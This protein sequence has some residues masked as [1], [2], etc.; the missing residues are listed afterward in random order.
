MASCRFFRNFIDLTTHSGKNRCR[1]IMKMTPQE[2]IL[3][4]LQL[5]DEMRQLCSPMEGITI[6]ENDLK[7]REIPTEDFSRIM[8]KL[9]S[10]GLIFPHTEEEIQLDGGLTYR[11]NVI[12]GDKDRFKNYANKIH[13]D[14]HSDISALQG[15]KFLA[16]ADVL[17]DIYGQLQITQGPEVSIRIVPQIVR[18]SSLMPADSVGMR[19]RYGDLR[20]EAVRYLHDRNLIVK[21]EIVH[22][23]HRWESEVSLSIDR[24]PFQSFYDRF[25]E[26]YE[27]RVVKDGQN[28]TPTQSQ[29]ALS[30]EDQRLLE[31]AKNR[32]AQI[33]ALTQILEKAEKEEV[34]QSTK[35]NKEPEEQTQAIKLPK[36]TSWEDVI[37]KFID[38]ENVKIFGKGFEQEASYKEMGFQNNKKV[39]RTPNKQ[40]LFLRSL[41]DLEGV[42]T[43]DSPRANQTLKKTKQLL[44]Y[45]LKAYFK[46]SG[47]P[48]GD[49]KTEKG[50]RIRMQLIPSHG[51]VVIPPE[52]KTDDEFGIEEELG[53]YNR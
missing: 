40:W 24:I 2:K 31:N 42:I 1:I 30:E 11:Y 25:A 38:G 19:D 35:T 41:A 39:P 13:T 7:E 46:L 51:S 15:E 34:G 44:S 21:Y 16:I 37:I 49:Y 53:K 27:K 28:Q 14:V 43:W 18:Y 22:G 36:G 8:R 20:M 50:Y 32:K 9:S 48:F 10:D 26:V 5:I 33:A 47:E 6:T 52:E 45:G 23:G 17:Y 3:S 12:I 29:N 4:I